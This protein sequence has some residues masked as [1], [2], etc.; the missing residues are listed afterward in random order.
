MMDHQV[1]K[2]QAESLVLDEETR[3]QLPG[4]FIS[5]PGGVT[6]Y[7]MA[8]PADGDIIVLV[9]GLSVPAYIW[10]P[11]F[12]ALS[13]AGL[14]VLRYDLYGRGFSDR[15]NAVYNLDLFV[16]Q[17]VDLL[18]ALEIST[19][20][21]LA[22]LSMGGPIAASFSVR[23]HER[24]NKL[25]LIDPAGFIDWHPLPIRLLRL[26]GVGELL[27]KYYGE[28]F[29]VNGQAGDFYRPQPF[30]EYGEKARP[31]MCYKGYQRA[32]LST[33]RKGPLN[34]QSELYQQLGRMQIPVLFVW[35][36]ED[37]TFP[38][39]LSSKALALVPQAELLAVDES[40]HIPHYER[41]NLVNP[42]LVN[43]FQ[44]GVQGDR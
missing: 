41:S 6:H 2:S 42:R 9:H 11:T 39:D 22:G 14:R 7:E 43:F 30:P 4:C 35:G 24:V 28:Q 5:L 32:L 19:P 10:D 3:Q 27:M 23:F 40:G 29:V 38:F 16:Q 34:G 31:Q 12:A 8:G 20:V 17:L 37:Q 18:E 15:P 36:K 1:A 44:Q 26:P 13:Q 25:C 33:L 21:G